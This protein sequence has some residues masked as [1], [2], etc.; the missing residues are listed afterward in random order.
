MCGS[1]PRHF[2]C[3]HGLASLAVPVLK[4]KSLGENRKIDKI[5]PAVIK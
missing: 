5:T 1:D 3:M 2:V 4:T